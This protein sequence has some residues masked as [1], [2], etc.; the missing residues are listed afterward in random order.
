MGWAKEMLIQMEEDRASGYSVP[1]RGEKL[2]CEEHFDNQ[3]L[4]AYIKSHGHEGICS[5]CGNKGTV[6]DLTDFIEYIG[7]KL[8]IYLED[9]DNAGLFLESSFYD[10]EDEEIPGYTRH[11]GYITPANVEY[12]DS[13]D[14]AIACFDLVPN[15]DALYDDIS[16]CLHMENKIRRN[17]TSLMLSEELSYL[18][19]Q[20]SDLVKNRQRF[21]FFRSSLFDDEVYKHSDNGLSDILSELR[22][23]V[24]KVEYIVPEGTILYRCRPVKESD[25]IEGFKDLTSPPAP[26]AKA[27]RLSPTGISM[28]YGS[29]DKNTSIKEVSSY[30][31]AS[32]ICCGTFK[33][34]KSLSV[35]NLCNLPQADFWMPSGWQEVSFMNHFHKEI[36]KPI[37]DKDNPDIEYIPSQI[38]TE[39]LRFLCKNTTGNPY[40]GVIY[41]SA[42]TGKQNIVLFYDQKSS[43][44]VLCLLKSEKLSD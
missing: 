6:L 39:Y 36:S 40:D 42:Q 38:F 37:G 14:E 25:K 12:Y 43:A 23:L 13:N 1:K 2:L 20:F 18:W 35:V 24:L 8:A 10:D 33:T 4:N 32:M 11:C 17:P 27:N 19:H 26:N 41:Q 3:Y 31:K 21:T 22:S 29:F 15:S 7:G 44:K 28:F 34:T 5:Y 30:M 9:I 16:S